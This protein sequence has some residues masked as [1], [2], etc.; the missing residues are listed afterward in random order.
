MSEQMIIVGCF[1]IIFL[2]LGFWMGRISSNQAIPGMKIPFKKPPSF[3]E[4]KDD[5]YE[6]AMTDKNVERIETI[7]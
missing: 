2:C 1:S 5:P 7:G 3:D 4:Y 6:V